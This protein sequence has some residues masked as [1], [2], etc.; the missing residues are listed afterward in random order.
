MVL[1]RRKI[2]ELFLKL[3]F[4]TSE[5]DI[6]KTDS[7]ECWVQWSSMSPFIFQT[8]TTVL[9]N[10]L[11]HSKNRLIILN[12]IEDYVLSVIKYCS[13][14]NLN[15]VQLYPLDFQSLVIL[16]R[17]EP[18][19][20]KFDPTFNDL[21]QFIDRSMKSHLRDPHISLMFL[22]HFPKWIPFFNLSYLSDI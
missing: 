16:L 7:I 12:I 4:E 22:S 10:I 14:K 17:V 21:V 1:D 20:I 19:T 15:F 8:I 18:S 3:Y 2:E 6:I 9:N 13:L 5:D 11:I